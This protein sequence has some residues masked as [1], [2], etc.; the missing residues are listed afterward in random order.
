GVSLGAF[1]LANYIWDLMMFIIPFV[2][3]VV[4]IKAF[5]ISSMTGTSDCFSCTSQTF[6]AVILLIALFGLAICPFTYC[7]S[8][9]FKEHASS[10]TYTTMINFVIGVVLMVTSFIMS[11][12][13]STKDI[14]AV[15]V[16]IWRLSPLFNLGSGLLN[17]VLNELDSVRDS[18]TEKKS[19][20]STDIMGWEMIFLVLIT[21]V[22]SALAVGIDYALTF[23]RVKNLLSRN[24]DSKDEVCDEDADV[25]KEAER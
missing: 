2:A 11:V 10:Q 20:F 3:A 22:F 21:V 13:E 4:L 7:L 1:W 15:L 19:P 12:I 8:Y 9:L 14:N 6:P 17:L 5:D 18:D 25:Q 23:P 16:F 24:G